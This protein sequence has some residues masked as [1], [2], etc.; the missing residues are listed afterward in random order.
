MRRITPCLWFDGRA[1]EA[2]NFYAGIF[3]NAKIGGIMRRGDAGPGQKGP[4]LSVT[5]ELDGQEFIG[6]NG[7]P[8]F[9]FSPAISF[10]VR[11]ETQEE[12]DRYWVR[13]LE[14]GTPQQCGWLTDKFGVSW[15]VVPAVLGDML[16][17]MDTAKADRVM[18]AMMQM[19]KLDIRLLQEAYDQ[20]V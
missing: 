8:M 11:C 15:Q 13:L 14:G 1:E 12:V 9:T 18:R 16:R 6:L 10:F 2:M 3:E 17:D 20:K 5:F 19:V 4:I 7:G